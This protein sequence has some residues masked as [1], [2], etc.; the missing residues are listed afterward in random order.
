MVGLLINTLPL[1]VQ[2]SDDDELLSWLKQIQAR[3]V[4]AQSYDYS[5]LIEVQKWS[6]VP[7]GQPLFESFITFLN[8]PVHNAVAEWDGPLEVRDLEFVERVNYALNLIASARGHFELELKY[9]TRRFDAAAVK[10]M[11]TVLEKLLEEFAAQPRSGVK[12][13]RQL[14]ADADRQQQAIKQQGF[15][16]ARRR[17][18]ENAKHKGAKKMSNREGDLKR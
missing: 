3:Q 11:L 9:D 4:E 17:L 1:R 5:P 6:D 7:R 12:R 16:E 2:V 14:V 18:L 15:N 13:L 10:R 8:Y